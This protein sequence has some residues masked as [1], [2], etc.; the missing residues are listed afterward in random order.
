MRK[1]GPCCRPVSVRPSVMLVYSIHTAEDIVK[2]LSPPG[3]PIPLVFGSRRR[4]PISRGIPSVG[5]QNTRGEKFANFDRN[6]RLSR[7]RYE[8]GSWLLLNAF[9]FL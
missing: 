5:A 6:R 3:S 7:K 8:I 2:L 4:Y 1:R 9:D